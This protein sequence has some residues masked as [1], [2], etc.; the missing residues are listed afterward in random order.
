VGGPVSG[1]AVI[2]LLCRTSDRTPGGARGAAVLA[3][4]L[5]DR[6]GAD[7]RMVGTPGEPRAG[8]WEEDLRASRGCILEAGGQVE[9]AISGERFPL[10]CA[11]DCTIALT[12]LPTVA[13]LVPDV[14]VLWL[15]AHGDF[16]TPSTSRSGFLGGMCL[17][18]ACGRWTTGFDGAVDAADVILVGSRD[19]DAGERAELDLAGVPRV[20]RPSQVADA[21]DGADVYVHLDLDVLDP[22]VFPAQFPAHG[23]LSDDG[24]HLLL[25]EV[26]QAAGRVVGVEITAFEA[27]EDPDECRRLATLAADAVMPLL[28]VAAAR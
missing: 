25:D 8:A 18:G 28:P 6:L 3:D 19:L 11:S 24:L 10:L 5:A 17:A 26:S 2:G 4:M 13:R 23:G 22:T 21:V 9:D 14:R 1:V 20:E 27:P 15:D 12:T 16:N 7:A